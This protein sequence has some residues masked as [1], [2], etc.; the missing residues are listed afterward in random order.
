MFF[1]EGGM[2]MINS[3]TIE[4]DALPQKARNELSEYYEFLLYKY[5]QQPFFTP[6]PV[7]ADFDEFLSTPIFI[8]DF[9]MPD[10][11]VCDM[12]SHHHGHCFYAVRKPD[13]LFR[14]VT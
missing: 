4:L 3:H 13:S 5:K 1:S 7:K 8:K 14:E 12:I 10:R 6:P 11:E 2:N 9:V